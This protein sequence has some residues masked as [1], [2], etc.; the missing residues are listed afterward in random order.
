MIRTM[1]RSSFVGKGFIMLVD[2]DHSL[3]A[4]ETKVRTQARNLEAE[5]Y[6]EAIKEC[7]LLS[8][9]HSTA[10]LSLLSYMTQDHLTGWYH[11]VV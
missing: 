3:I 10:L 8:S 1:T 9:L 2:P 6:A 5:T 11:P 7:S 4:K